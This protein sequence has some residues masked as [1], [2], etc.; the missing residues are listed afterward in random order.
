MNSHGDPG[1]FLTRLL[2]GASGGPAIFTRLAFRYTLMYVDFVCVH[3]WEMPQRNYRRPDDA[4]AH[5]HPLLPER[6][7]SQ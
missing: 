5:R 1:R 3:V 7:K 4:A 2:G 6:R